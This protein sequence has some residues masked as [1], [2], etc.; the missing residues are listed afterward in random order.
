MSRTQADVD[1]RGWVEA[2]ALIE[3]DY[4]AV[5]AVVVGDMLITLLRHA[6]RVGIACQAQ[7]ANVIGPIRTRTGGPAWRQSI[8]HPFALT[9]RHARGTVLRT[10]PAGP[11]HETAKHG[12]VPTVDTVAVHDEET[13]D[14]AVFA[15]NRGDTPLS[16][17][18]DLRGL[19]A[20]TGVEHVS[21]SAGAAPE[22]YNTEEAP[23]RVRPVTHDR[24]VVDAGR[25]AVRLEPASW[26]LLR[27]TAA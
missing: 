23:D 11:T 14:L 26:N 3:D 15:V 16:L 18:L 13:G 10:E 12:E 20:L 4:T 7:L 8:F 5:D 22:A 25:S 27:F 24:P 21:V 17:D 9:A 6:D 2:P 1:R 19:P